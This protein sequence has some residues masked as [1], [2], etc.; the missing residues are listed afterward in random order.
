[1]GW[2]DPH[3]QERLRVKIPSICAVV[4]GLLERADEIVFE[5]G[6]NL[7]VFLF[8]FSASSSS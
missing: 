7:V 5:E 1:M 4:V 6:L 2:T 3:H 8:V